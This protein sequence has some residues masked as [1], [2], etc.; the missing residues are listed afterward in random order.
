MRTNELHVPVNGV[1]HIDIKALDVLHSVFIPNIRLKQDALPGRTITRWFEATKTGEYDIVCAEIC[2]LAHAN[3]KGT[4]TVD[5]N[6]DFL[7]YLDE[8]YK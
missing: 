7:A 2:G 8:I 1:V 6:K 3:M 4:L 5:S